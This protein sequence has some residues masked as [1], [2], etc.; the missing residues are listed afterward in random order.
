MKR[1]I[2]TAGALAVSSAVILA[3]C[4]SGGGADAGG[5]AGPSVTLT[6]TT[7]A[8]EAS[9]SG[10][11][12]KAWGDYLEEASE[13]QIEIEY[14]W[15]AALLGAVEQLSGVGAGIADF[16]TSSSYVFNPQE[17][18]I[19]NWTA[20]LTTLA[21]VGAYPYPT[22]VGTAAS[23]ELFTSDTAL[24]EE[25][26]GHDVVP[27]GAFFSDAYNLI[28]TK[29]VTTLAEAQGLRI[30][31]AGAAWAG[32][33][34]ALGMVP[35]SLPPNE[36][37]EALQRG[38]IDC[39]AFPLSVSLDFGLLEVAPYV[40][41]VPFSPSANQALIGVVGLDKL[42]EDLSGLLTEA[43]NVLLR[44]S[45]EGNLELLGETFAPG[46]RAEELGIE[47]VM[48]PELYDAVTAHQKSVRDGMLSNLPSGLDEADAKAMID[49]YTAAV[50]KWTAAL[51]GAGI[52]DSEPAT[53]EDVIERWRAGGDIAAFA[54]FFE[55]FGSR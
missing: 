25:Y 40:M 53:A 27:L 20:P 13:G 30:R 55:E 28:C 18:P 29:P 10:Q 38:V 19:A 12:V 44:A 24:L 33:A 45:I 32:E 26:A 5:D 11:A 1:T 14:Y 7:F 34:E 49:A 47:V 39:T 17:L 2:L 48:A 8:P 35:V 50:K 22:L 52:D 41:W 42:G 37:Y 16:A 36:Q 3:G 15:S 54:P 6:V 43:T 46:G 23:T 21:E 31:S 51:S 4:T 9:V